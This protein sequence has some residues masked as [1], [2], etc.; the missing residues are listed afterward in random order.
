[1][2][3]KTLVLVT[4]FRNQSVRI[5]HGYFFFSRSYLLL[6]YARKLLISL[7]SP[8]TGQTDPRPNPTHPALDP[9]PSSLNRSSMQ[10]RG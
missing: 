1:M 2:P 8:F 4:A 9:N 5:H 10:S 6:N 3:M 7:T